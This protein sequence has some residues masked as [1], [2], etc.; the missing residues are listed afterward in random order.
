LASVYLLS[1]AP[2][3]PG[4]D[5]KA[6]LDL[7]QMRASAQADRFGVHGLVED[8]A[9]ADLILF[10]ETS[11]AAGYYFEL[12]RRHPVYRR[13]R[14]KSYL[15]SSTDRIV[16]FLPGVFA[17]LER[18]WYWPAWT[19]S[20][21]YLGVGERPGLVYEPELEPTLLF[22]FVGSAAAHPVRGRIAAL[23][24]P[25]A[26]IFDG[27]AEAAAVARGEVAAPTPEEFVGRYAASLRDAAFVLCPR[28]GGSSSFRLFEAM[29]LGRAPVVVSDQWVAPAG[30]GWED[31]SLRVPEREVERIPALLEE[32][33]GEARRMGEAARAAWLEWFSPQ[34]GFHRTI[35]SCLEL[36]H[37]APSRRG[38]RRWAPYLQLLRPYHAARATLKRVR[39]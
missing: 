32:R 17:S 6:W 24:H 37:A 2:G 11:G 12:V 39:G 34:A 9:S 8:S 26:L 13:H 36:S 7:E 15:F 25:E 19:R 5:P 28:G 23:E 38:P 20:G 27:S 31:F 14:E 3:G 21:H 29:M 35:E 22:S 18:R 4:D 10:V 16:P 30:P 1:A 33:R